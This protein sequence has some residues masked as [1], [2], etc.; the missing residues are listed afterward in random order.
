MCRESLRERSWS[1]FLLTCINM[2]KGVFRFWRGT[3]LCVCQ[4]LVY[5]CLQFF[6]QCGIAWLVPQRLVNQRL[7]EQH[8]RIFGSRAL[9]LFARTIAA[10]V[11]IAGVREKPIHFDFDQSGTLA[12][13][14]PL[15]RLARCFIDGKRLTPVHYTARH[16]IS[17]RA[18]REIADSHLLF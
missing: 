13:P 14:R 18:V 1:S 2:S 6:T 5:T 9:D 3:A 11:V 15:N 12:C 7:S 16:A 10:V 17:G 4:C 8:H